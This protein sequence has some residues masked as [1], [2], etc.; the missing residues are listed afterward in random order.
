MTIPSPNMGLVIFVIITVIYF[1]VNYV[2]KEK[3]NAVAF[4]IYIILL[5]AAQFGISVSLTKSLCGETH[6]KTAF[7]YTLIP[8]ILIFGMLNL[9]LLMFP[10]WLKPFSNTIGYFIVSFVGGLN[11]LLGNILKSKEKTQNQELTQTL[12]KIYDNPALLINEIPNPSVGFDDFWSK[13]GSGNLLAS[14]AEN[15]KEKLRELVMLKFTISKFIWFLL[16]GL[17][18]VSTS[19][20]YLVKSG[21]NTSVKEM[22]QRHNDYERM[23]AEKT[24]NTVKNERVYKDTGH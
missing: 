7:L 10:G 3:H 4:M 9:M 12:G 13:L 6:V 1:I 18:T 11:N 2:T 22:V 14:G 21:C 20:N 15:F 24:N 19:Y 23:V 16:T 8:W 5:F 17:L